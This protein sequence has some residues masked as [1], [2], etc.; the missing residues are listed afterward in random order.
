ME[1]SAMSGKG[2]GR[3]STHYP[4][5]NALFFGSGPFWN[6]EIKK[7]VLADPSVI[8]IIFCSLMEAAKKGSFLSGPATGAFNPPSPRLSGRRNFFPY[9]KKVLFSLVSHPFS[10]PPLLVARPLRKS[11]FFAASLR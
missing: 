4:L 6:Y 3:R 2:E 8:L 7:K 9:I 1:V 10:P 5:K 11:L